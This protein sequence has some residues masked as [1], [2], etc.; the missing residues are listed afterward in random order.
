MILILHS[1]NCGGYLEETA[2]YTNKYDWQDVRD[3]DASSL[4]PIPKCH[5]VICLM[6]MV[7]IMKIPSQDRLLLGLK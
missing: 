3:M 6:G 4:P 7:K 1:T 5:P 2:K